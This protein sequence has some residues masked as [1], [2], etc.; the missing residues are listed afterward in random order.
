MSMDIKRYMCF[1]TVGAVPRCKQCG[2]LMDTDEYLSYPPVDE[3]FR[4]PFICPNNHCPAKH[5][6]T[7]HLAILHTPLL[8]VLSLA[9]ESE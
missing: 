5:G 1:S 8:Q 6:W 7:H 4:V 3:V 2:T 9:P